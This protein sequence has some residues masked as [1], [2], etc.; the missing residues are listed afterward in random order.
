MLLYT[1][2]FTLTSNIEGK[3]MLFKLILSTTQTIAI[4]K[5]VRLLN[6]QSYVSYIGLQHNYMQCIM[7]CTHSYPRVYIPCT[8]KFSIKYLHCKLTVYSNAVISLSYKADYL[9]YL[10]TRYLTGGAYVLGH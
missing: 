7:Y 8:V 1:S 3:T 2:P 6:S 10:D 4:L 9:R 5:N